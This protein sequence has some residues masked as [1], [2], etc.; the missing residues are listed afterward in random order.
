MLAW[1][2]KSANPSSYSDYVINLPNDELWL[3]D[4]FGALVP[5]MDVSNW[6][7]HGTLTPQEMADKWLEILSSQLWSLPL[8]FPVGIIV[9]FGGTVAPVGW[10]MVEHV[11]VSK[12]TYA[13]L[14][15]VIGTVFGEDTVDEF[16]LPGTEDVFIR[17]ASPINT[18]GVGGGQATVALTVNQLPVHTHTQQSHNHTQQSHNHTQSAHAHAVNGGDSASIS[19]FDGTA[20]SGTFGA[21]TGTRLVDTFT[22]TANQTA[23]NVA[24]TAVNNAVV[25]VNNNA[26]NNEPH[27]NIP[28]FLTL[29]YIIKF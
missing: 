18:V 7:Q 6:E 25:A 20:G 24:Q 28:P 16:W 27:N 4:F 22:N 9:P 13:N 2:S 23:V 17:G 29:N 14:F 3:A 1:L 15:S 19:V 12:T 11:L 26:G 10:L 21:A 8:A 5:L